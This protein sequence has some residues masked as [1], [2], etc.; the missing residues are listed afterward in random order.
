VDFTKVPGF[1]VLT[2]Q[3]IISEVG[4]NP[5]KWPTE[6]HFTSWLGLSPANKITGEK[7]KS[8]KTR[9]INNRASNAFRL[10][11]FA[12]ARSQT[13]LGGYCRRMKNRLGTPKAITAC[14]RKLACIFYNL[15][16][17]GQDYVEKGLDHYEK[18]YQERIIKN[19]NKKAKELGFV[20]MKKNDLAVEVS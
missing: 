9:K 1:D 18:L 17:Y 3:T 11:A 2:I 12:A 16:K 6:K 4:L 5:H 19:L 15:L 7:I 13:A 10:A 14:A 20:L 8:S